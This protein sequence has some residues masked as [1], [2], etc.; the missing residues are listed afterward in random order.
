M[1]NINMHDVVS[2]KL[3]EIHL[4]Q[5]FASRVLVLKAQSK[6]DDT[7]TTH[8]IA[9]YSELSNQ[10]VPTVDNKI[11]RM[12]SAVEADNDLKQAAS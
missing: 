3:E 4:H 1:I 10:L 5:G 11:I 9:L 7:P 8:R 6:Y 12:P 2:I